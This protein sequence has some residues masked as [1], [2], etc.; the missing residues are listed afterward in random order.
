MHP[1]PPTIQ[2]P[3][4]NTPLLSIALTIAPVFLTAA[5]YLTLSRIFLIYNV[6]LSR[7]A[8]RTV[9]LTFMASDFLSLVLQA[10]GG[11]I[12]DTADYDQ[13]D[14]KRTGID[15][16]ISVAGTWRRRWILG[17]S[18]RMTAEGEDGR[19]PSPAE[20]SARRRRPSSPGSC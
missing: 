15:I 6:S 16:M 12:A 2:N 13:Q 19:A 17:S 7:F 11:G 3:I 18:P 20:A 14:L 5:I 4:T 8:P 9:A 1:P 10:A